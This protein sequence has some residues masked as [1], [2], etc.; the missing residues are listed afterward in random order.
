MCLRCARKPAVIMANILFHF[1]IPNQAI[2]HLFVVFEPPKFITMFICITCMSSEHCRINQLVKSVCIECRTIWGGHMT[3]L[4]SVATYKQVQIVDFET[5]CWHSF[6]FQ[7]SLPP[8]HFTS[9]FVG[10]HMPLVP[11]LYCRELRYRWC[12]PCIYVSF[13]WIICW[14]WP[15]FLSTWGADWAM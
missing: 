1:I 11:H 5:P 14:N 15:F 2:A 6:C 4:L 9:P 13:H 7:T 12:M 8:S 3:C 10:G